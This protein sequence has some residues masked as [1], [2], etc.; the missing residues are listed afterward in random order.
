MTPESTI[1]EYYESLERGE[2]LYPFFAEREG[3]VKYGIGERLVGYDE[4]VEGLQEQNRTTAAWRVDSRALRV[5]RATGLAY[6]S[7][8]VE[9]SWRDTRADERVSFDTRWSGT[10]E[11]VDGEW[12]FVGMHV[13]V[14]VP[15]ESGRVD[16]G[17]PPHDHPNGRVD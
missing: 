8:V 9:L 11:S 14:A 15:I 10:L 3:V 4:I 6:F 16:P 2:P 12:R 1:R 13:S 17:K 7:D 5:D